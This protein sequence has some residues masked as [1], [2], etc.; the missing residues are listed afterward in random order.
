MYP[1][2][3]VC[4]YTALKRFGEEKIL[5]LCLTWSCQSTQDSEETKRCGAHWTDAPGTVR[6]RKSVL[7]EA[8][9]L[10]RSLRNLREGKVSPVPSTFSPERRVPT[11]CCPPALI[12][13]LPSHYRAEYRRQCSSGSRLLRTDH[14]V[15]TIQSINVR[16]TT[17]LCSWKCWNGVM[18]AGA[19]LMFHQT[20]STPRYYANRVEWRLGNLGVITLFAFHYPLLVSPNV[21]CSSFIVS[22]PPFYDPFVSVP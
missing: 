11:R 14:T 8:P 17:H 4:G 7:S 1:A 3:A 18:F 15:H 22:E 5:A 21:P 9:S 19:F 12:T 13:T 20:C 10:S 2:P 16:P 6:A